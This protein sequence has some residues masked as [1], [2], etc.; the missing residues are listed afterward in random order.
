M[1]VL[2]RLRRPT[3]SQKPKSRRRITIVAYLLDDEDAGRQKAV[4]PADPY[5]PIA[6]L[7]VL[8]RKTSWHKVLLPTTI[9]QR[10]LDSSDK[11]L[12]LR[13]LCLE[14]NDETEVVMTPRRTRNKK[15][16]RKSTRTGRPGSGGGG[17]GESRRHPVETS[18]LGNVASSTNRK[19]LHLAP[20]VGGD[21]DSRRSPVLIISTKSSSRFRETG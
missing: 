19:S 18:L 14:C 10:V 1:K 15:T 9:V 5:L 6:Q 17:G 21:G 12:R 7:T 2:V 8:V 4:G 3:E 16:G 20:P 13:V 11:V